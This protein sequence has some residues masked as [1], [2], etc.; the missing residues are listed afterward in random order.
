MAESSTGRQAG[1]P[2]STGASIDES[3]DPARIGVLSLHNSKETK[4]ILN[5][6]AALGCTPV[7]LREENIKTWIADND[8]HFSPDVDVVL[9]RLLVTKSHH[10]LEDLELAGIYQT[11]RTVLNAPAAVERTVHKY[12]AAGILARAG[13]PVPNAFIARS[14]APFYDYEDH[15]EGVVANKQTIG[16]NGDSMR[17]VESESHPNPALENGQAF[18]QEYLDADPDRHWDVRAYVVG[19]RVIGAMKRYAPPG[20]WRTNVARGGTVEDVT[21]SL[22][23]RVERLAIDAT[24]VLGLDYSGVDLIRSSGS[25]YVLEVNATAG[26]KGL[27]S[28]TGVSPAPYIASLG[29]EAVDEPV[30][31]GRVRELS[32]ELDDSTPACKPEIPKAGDEA[33]AVLGYT[34]SATVS[35]MAGS[36]QA[37]AKAD[38][39]A[40]RTSIDVSLAGRVGAGPV[41]DTAT[42]RSGASGGKE[43][44]PVVEL[45]LEVKGD[46]HEITA[47]VADRSEMRYPILLGRDVLDA[48]LLDITRRAEE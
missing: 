48:Y 25:W 35:G 32:G 39:G 15:V 42:V 12:R 9:N 29:V 44:R 47:S 14:P 4:A 30:E 31:S 7:W 46:W 13:I 19:D 40:R 11:K 16:T 23:E 2:G 20:D 34:A 36:E 21:E 41:V 10:P 22:P 17:L 38:T 37:M 24:H 6:I 27:F 3:T 18:I 43:T 1:P 33:Q 8:V 5:A 45:A 28:A 26:F